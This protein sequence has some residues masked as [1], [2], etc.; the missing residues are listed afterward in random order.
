MNTKE[1]R[2]EPNTYIKLFYSTF[3]HFY[4]KDNVNFSK[5]DE[6]DALDIALPD[7]TIFKIMDKASKNTYTIKASF[8]HSSKLF[9]SFLFK[10]IREHLFRNNI[11]N[12]TDVETEALGNRIYQRACSLLGEYIRDYLHIHIEDITELSGTYYEHSESNG[13]ICFFLTSK[14]AL[15]LKLA[16]CAFSDKVSFCGTNIRKIRKLLEIT[17]GTSSKEPLGLAFAFDGEW[18]LKGFTNSIHQEQQ[19]I[20]FN[21]VKHMVWDMYWGTE[22][23]RYNCGKY[24]SSKTNYKAL[25][26]KRIDGL[27]RTEHDKIWPLVHAAIHQTQGTTL[28]IICEEREVIE[29]RVKELLKSSS[30]TMLD[31]VHLDPQYVSRLTAIDGALIIDNEGNGYGYG[32]ILPFKGSTTIKKDPG[33]G[34]RFNSAK[35]YIADQSKRG[36]KAMAVIVSEDGMVHFYSTDDAKE[37][38]EKNAEG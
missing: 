26:K 6:D 37:E 19:L 30:G 5:A 14:D 2:E 4:G 3:S 36:M 22:T 31:T 1:S 9:N 25:F 7:C 32:M 28:I 15:C 23:L 12:L 18:W 35:L 24:I 13:N 16:N 21:F 8:A 27:A 33:R 29:D 10:S 11:S 20:C 38:E 34:A 17:N